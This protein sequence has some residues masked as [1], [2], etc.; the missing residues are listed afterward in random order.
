MKVKWGDASEVWVNA[1]EVWGNARKIPD[2]HKISQ[3][4][5]SKIRKHPFSQLIIKNWLIV[6]MFIRSE[7]SSRTRFVGGSVCL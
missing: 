2:E 7:C 6:S 4:V 3:K 1:S 5:D